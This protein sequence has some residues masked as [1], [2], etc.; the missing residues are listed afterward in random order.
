M[1]INI[2]QRQLSVKDKIDWSKRKIRYKNLIG[3]YF[4]ISIK[5]TIQ[6]VGFGKNP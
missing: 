4:K 2:K 5:L 6:V 3:L 1:K